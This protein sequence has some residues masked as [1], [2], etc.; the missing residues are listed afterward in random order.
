MNS[1]ELVIPQNYEPLPVLEP[2]F[3]KFLSDFLP[4]DLRDF[5]NGIDKHIQ[6]Y[7]YH[8]SSSQEHFFTLVH[9]E[10]AR[11]E[12]QYKAYDWATGMWR[13]KTSQS[14]QSSQRRIK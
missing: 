12:K 5:W 11:F 13:T 7:L 2:E 10:Y 4:V 9:M 14:S 8:S 6:Y 3:S 1:I